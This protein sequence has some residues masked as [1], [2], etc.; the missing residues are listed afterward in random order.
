LRNGGVFT[1]NNGSVE[2]KENGAEIGFGPFGGIGLK[3]GLDIDDEGGA[4]RGEQT[5]LRTRST[6]CS[7]NGNADT[8]KNQGGVE[9]LVVLRHVFG[10]VLCRLSL[11]HGV[12]IELGVVVLDRLEVHA[13]GL[14]N[15][16]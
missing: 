13:Q 15:A 7:G 5:S 4:D 3:V 1:G 16:W 2:A 10:I 8:H 9:I 12:E 6:L 14:L 11:V